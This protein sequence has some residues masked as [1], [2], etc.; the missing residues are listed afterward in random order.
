MYLAIGA[1]SIPVLFLMNDDDDV[2]ETE[3]GTGAAPIAIQTSRT[4]FAMIE[5]LFQGR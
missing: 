5:N 4:R 3:I 1:G 2:L